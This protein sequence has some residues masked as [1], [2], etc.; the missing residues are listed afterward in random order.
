MLLPS[1]DTRLYSYRTALSGALLLTLLYF[2]FYTWLV[3]PPLVLFLGWQP[4]TQLRVLPII[5]EGEYERYVQSGDI[6][7]A[8]DGRQVQRGRAV[9]APPSKSVYELT[10]Q[11]G[12]ITVTE[13]VPVGGKQF[14]NVWILTQTLL[15]LAIWAVGFVTA[16]F[17][18][19]GQST[20]VYTGLGFQLIATGIVSA[21]P[22]LLGAPGGWIVGHVL[23]V[24]FP[25][26]VL[27]L[28]FVPSERPLPVWGRRLLSGTFYLLTVVALAAAAEVLFLFP[29]Q[30]W[31]TIIGIRTFTAIAV[32]AG[33]GVILSTAILFHRLIRSV[34]GSYERQQLSILFFMWALALVPLFVFVILPLDIFIFVPF[35]FVYSLFLFAPA[36]Y[37]FV[38]HRQGYLQLDFVFSRIITFLALLVAVAMAYVTA[39]YLF[40]T[41]FHLESSSLSRGGLTFLLVG[42]AVLGQRRVQDYVDLLLFGRDPLGPASIQAARLK[43]S[44]N[45]EPATIGEVLNEVSTSLQ[46]K[47]ATVLAKADGQFKLLAGNSPPSTLPESPLYHQ[48]LL[49][50]R[51][52]DA[53][54][55]LPPWVEL[56]IPIKARGE[57]LGLL[58]LARPASGYFNAQQVDTLKAIA[59]IFALGLLVITLVG[60]MQELSRQALYEKELQRQRI[61]T[62]I[63]NESLQTLTTAIMQLQSATTDKA[64]QN[65]IETIRTVAHDLRRII[66]DLRPPIM[67][68]SVEW[69]TRQ[70]VR[71]FAERHDDIDVV[72]R[73][74]DIR[75]DRPASETT[76][77]AFCYILTE[78]LN[79]I[80]QHA[81]A[82]RVE[83]ALHYDEG[84]LVLEVSDNGA[85]SEAVARPLTE[86]LRAHHIGVADMHRWALIGGGKLMLE[87]NTPSG[88]VVKLELPTTAPNITNTPLY[89]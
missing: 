21:G 6:V 22:S 10:L 37:F 27:Y 63:H 88:V 71:E 20:A 4:D 76:K 36:G 84:L 33:C 8:V 80:S 31:Q 44:T 75:S 51:D 50:T 12:E 28:A 66:A 59:D 72:L 55:S 87:P 18:Q 77:M 30:S 3:L 7:L 15:A 56:S 62:E 83:V 74:M 13:L 58:L 53:L 14:F 54:L 86:L 45:P 46:V 2:A 38:L 25:F 43:L 69:I 78:A 9:F 79:N 81:R 35:P 65:V 67:K 23:I 61:A 73:L 5:V 26:I 11:R 57:M 68:E 34:K 85:G 24:Y 89:S 41:V 60:T 70:T 17:A 47:Q 1:L 39:S 48:A 49:R 42:I 32:L 16:R 64:I 19:A 29:D 82:T 40:Q 52:R